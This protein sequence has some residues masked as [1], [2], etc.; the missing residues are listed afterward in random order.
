VLVGVGIRVF[1][2][3]AEVNDVYRVAF[4]PRPISK[5]LGL[6]SGCSWSGCAP[7]GWSCDRPG[8][9]GSWG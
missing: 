1:L 5:L 2:G 9:A 4:S 8:A 7:K 3:Q 6:T